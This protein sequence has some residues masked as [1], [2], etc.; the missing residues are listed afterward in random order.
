MNLSMHSFTSNIMHV[1]IDD[2]TV[3][4]CHNIMNGDQWRAN[5]TFYLVTLKLVMYARGKQSTHVLDIQIY[6]KKIN[7][8]KKY[9]KF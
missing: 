1:L 2:L 9:Y 5:A 3:C 4:I 8:I 7:K 6:F